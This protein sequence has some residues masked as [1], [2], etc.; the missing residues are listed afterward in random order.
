MT[1]H[2]SG[3]HALAQQ[4]IAA[5][6]RFVFGNPGTTEQAFIDALIDYPELK[7]VLCL[8]E[9]V[10]VGAAEGF[11]RASNTPGVVLLHTAPGLGNGMG[12]LSNARLGGTPLVVLVGDMPQG[13]LFGE[14]ALSGPI[15]EMARSVAVWAYQLRSADEVPQAVR[16]AFKVAVDKRGPVV[17]VLPA[18]VMEE[19]TTQVVTQPRYV[20]PSRTADRASIAQAAGLLRSAERPAIVVGDGVTGEDGPGA[21]SSLAAAL[22]APIFQGYVTEVAVLPGE[23]L[24][25]GVLPLFDPTALRA[26][27]AGFDCVLALGTEVFKQA[28]AEPGSPLADDV[29]LIHIGADTWELGKNQPGLLIQADP[30]A[31]AKQLLECLLHRGPVPGSDIRAAEVRVTVAEA[32]AARGLVAQAKWDSS[33][34]SPARAIYEIFEASPP[35][36]IIVDEAV[37]TAPWINHYFAAQPGRWFRSRGGGLGAGMTLPLGVKLAR[38]DETVIAIVG[39]GA[40][41]Y[42]SAALWTAAHLGLGVVFVVVNNA[43]Y[44]MLKLN[45]TAYLGL[46]DP[47]RGFVGADLVD[48]LIEF[49]RHAQSMGVPAELVHEPQELALAVKRAIAS[50][51][52]RLIEVR[53]DGTID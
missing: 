39:D 8:Q 51:G 22:G 17:L 14:P 15:L 4:L 5:G 33:P 50:G 2:L 18:D 10:A 43:S 52:P 38:P 32:A 7:F 37:S 44:R 3:R 53:I 25:A 16:R 36:T 26:Q 11:S 31:A 46:R 48:P 20:V 30:T 23:A 21:V 29:A 41:M 9:A 19:S 45:T 13:S 12:M 6:T 40:A 49:V 24:N 42:T 28:F 34:M 27:M 47:D 1:G 35:D